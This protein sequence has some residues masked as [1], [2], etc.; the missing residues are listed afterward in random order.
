M[1]LLADQ[2]DGV[3]GVDTHRDTLTA[4]VVGPIGAVLANAQVP[5]DADGYGRLLELARQHVPG[6]RCWALEGAGSYGAG[7][8]EFLDT[9]E[10]QVIEVCRPKR[11]ATRGGRKTDALDA[12]RA[13]R[14]AFTS[15]HLIHPRRRGEREAL[16]V[17]LATL[18]GAVLARTAAVNQLKALIV[19]APEA[20]R[21]E[22]RGRTTSR[23]M[24]YCQARTRAPR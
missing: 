17:L 5:A 12:V 6:R 10:E 14:E 18:A 24:A 3:V 2:I 21:T 20:R 13:A 22:L 8:A 4:A 7:L 9:A 15:E 1:P 11:P 19:S 23:Q 16:R